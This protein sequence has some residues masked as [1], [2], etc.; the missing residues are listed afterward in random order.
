MTEDQITEILHLHELWLQGESEGVRADLIDADLSG[1]AL[2][3]A[4]LI[5]AD[6][7]T[8]GEEP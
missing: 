8:E 7:I 1:A 6:L 5:E 2:S 4:N 3:G